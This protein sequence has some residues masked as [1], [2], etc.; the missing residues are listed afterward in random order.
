MGGASMTIII[1]LYSCLHLQYPLYPL[2]PR[3]LPTLLPPLHPSLHPPVPLHPPLQLENEMRCVY[4]CVCV[5]SLG[6]GWLFSFI[7]NNM[8]TITLLRMSDLS[9]P[10]TMS[11]RFTISTLLVTMFSFHKVYYHRVTQSHNCYSNLSVVIWHL[12]WRPENYNATQGYILANW[13]WDWAKAC[14]FQAENVTV[15]HTWVDMPPQ[16]WPTSHGRLQLRAL[17]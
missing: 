5:C 11:T 15:L 12:K 14:D 8:V 2:L 16:W 17:L 7:Q 10:L 3:L 13:Q 4:V 9:R 1:V 6:I